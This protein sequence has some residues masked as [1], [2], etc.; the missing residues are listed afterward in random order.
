MSTTT[1]PRIVCAILDMWTGGEQT[2]IVRDHAVHS[3]GK[4]SRERILVLDRPG[5]DCG[6]DA[7]TA[8]HEPPADQGM[9]EQ[10]CVGLGASEQSGDA[11]R[12]RTAQARKP[13]PDK[14]LKG[15][16]LRDAGA[17]VRIRK[18]GRQ[19]RLELLELAQAPGAK[20]GD[21]R[22]VEQIMIT[23]STNDGALDAH[24]LEID[25]HAGFA[26]RNES[27]RGLEGRTVG[28]QLNW[29][30][31]ESERT[32]FLHRGHI[33]FDQID[34]VIDR[35]CERCERVL[36]GKHRRAPV[37]DLEHGALPA[38]IHGRG[39]VGS[40]CSSTRPARAM[41][42]TSMRSVSHSAGAWSSV[43]VSASAWTACTSRRKSG[44]SDP[45]AGLLRPPRRQSPR[46][47]KGR[48]GP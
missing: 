23:E 38:Q 10:R 29:R 24:R 36:G 21:G 16:T 22:S 32:R 6:P 25:D 5:E 37:A 7:M 3:C 31:R 47:D 9:V 18:P 17:V 15:R 43:S 45:A 41:N 20:R 46:R 33:D 27:Q 44:T 35:G 11:R 19:P 39:P 13:G 40:G 1:A 26:L 30:M 28:G 42:S 12:K 14:R 34:A 48:G 2:G 8:L 4:H